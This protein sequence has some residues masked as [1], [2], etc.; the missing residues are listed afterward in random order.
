M[1]VMQAT[2]VPTPV[3]ILG[4]FPGGKFPPGNVSFPPGN[5]ANYGSQNIGPPLKN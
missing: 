1:S 2:F 3:I 4:M 5:F